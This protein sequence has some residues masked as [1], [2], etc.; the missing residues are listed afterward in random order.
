MN[1]YNSYDYNPYEHPEN[2][3]PPKKPKKKTLWVVLI[4]V[5]AVLILGTIS[6]L[7]ARCLM[8][9]GKPAESPS[10]SQSEETKPSTG[11]ED[12]IGKTEPGK[13]TA[14]V[15]DLSG[16]VEEV[17][18]SV[19]SITDTLLVSQSFNPYNYFFSF[20]SQEPEEQVAAGSGVIYS[21]IGTDL[22]IVT[23]AHVVNNESSSSYQEVSSKGLKVTFCDGT[24][25]DA[26][27]KGMD[28]ASDLALVIVDRKSVV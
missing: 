27:I 16:L 21:Q 23:N 3:V 17:I 13:I 12:P 18:P 5:A 1:D 25:A 4:I 6:I 9:S 26:K 2:E 8:D 7:M 14:T 15:L 24:T 20:G 28:V 11:K 10:V 22:Y 19:V